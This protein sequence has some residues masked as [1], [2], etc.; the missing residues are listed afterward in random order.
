[1]ENHDGTFRLYVW[2]HV[3]AL[4]AYTPGVAA[5]AARSKEDAINAVMVSM[6]ANRMPFGWNETEDAYDDETR[7]EVREK[8]NALR[9]ELE[10]TPP[11]ILELPAGV[12]VPGGD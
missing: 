7:A 3:K 2:R 12:V 10:N 5:A 11:E 8:H 1:M 9:A 4:E 6:P